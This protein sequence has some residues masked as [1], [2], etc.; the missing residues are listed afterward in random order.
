MRRII[1]FVILLIFYLSCY[2]THNRAGEITYKQLSGLTFEITITTY[3]ATCPG[4]CA[5]RPELKI[6]WGD[7]TMSTLPRIEKTDLPDCY[8]RN[9]YKG[10]HT[11]PGPGLYSLVVEDPNRNGGVANI[12]NSIN[13]VFSISTTMYINPAI[14]INN[15]PILTRA[16]LDKAAVGRLFI[17]NPGAYDPD[18]D[19]LAYRLTICRSDN[20]LPIQG[21]SFPPASDTLYVD[22]ING[23]FIWKNPTEV[24][25]YNVAMIIEEWR[26]GIKINEIIR[27]MQI[28][29]FKD[30]N[31]PPVIQNKSDYFCVEAG[32]LILDTIIANDIDNNLI[33][34]SASGAPLLLENSYALFNVDSTSAGFARG[35]FKWNTSCLNIRKQP[36][37]VI[38]KAI[39]DSPKVPLSFMK[40]I[41]IKIIGP[42]VKNLKTSSSSNYIS[43]NWDKNIC[44]NAI[45]YNIYRKISSTNFVPDSCFTGLP[46]E[47][48][49]EKIT[50]INGVGVNFY[51]DF[52][53]VQGHEYCYRICTVWESNGEEFEGYASEESCAV[54]KRG[55]PTITNVSVEKTNETNGRI[56]IAWAKPKEDEIG[57]K[58]TGPFQYVLYRSI[59]FGGQNFTEIHRFDDI[60]D[61]VY[62]DTLLNTVNNA[63]SYKVE[64]YNNFPNNIFLIGSPDI[65]SSVF[66]DIIPLENKNK[67]F[68]TKNVPWINKEYVLYKLNN[69]TQNYDSVNKISFDS[70][71]IDN[72]IISGD[73]YCYFIKSLGSYTIDGIIDPI[74]NYS[75]QKCIINID[76]FP[77]CVPILTVKSVCDSAYNDISWTRNDTCSNDISLYKLFYKPTL[78]GDFV[79]IYQDSISHFNHFP[80]KSLAGCYYVTALDAFN[81]ESK[82]SE[83]VC[84]DNCISYM[85]PNVF[86]P[87]G[88]GINDIYYPKRPYYFVEKVDMKIYNRWGDLIFETADPDIKWDGKYMKNNKPVADGVYFYICDVYEQ[89]LTGT[90][91]RHLSGF[92]HVYGSIDRKITISE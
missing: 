12:P 49:Y 48:G 19:S 54:L 55:I 41:N 35:I 31:S 18:G 29:V 27:D 76:T 40:T 52:D 67:I 14:G 15:T 16:P 71:F 57:E 50:F 34:L 43:L 38:V 22:A 44:L 32:N 61:T 86:T 68:F 1:T 89:R 59:G 63:Y 46:E 92:I 80:I 83:I 20:G 7:N 62:I 33:T 30:T 77:P 28:E 56:Y 3:T 60:N 75:Q 79:K 51:Q 91:I 69:S 8:R 11:F 66:L 4:E 65:A 42:A 87:N 90:E 24:G 84:V 6:M 36:Y 17:H 26:K 10:I 78:D 25:V 73:E 23:D 58:A 81:N 37:S 74:I 2:A 70:Y 21:Y 72:Q 47:L 64:F 88:D 45:G 82:P 13:T 5:D 9:R 85:L 39:D 53:L